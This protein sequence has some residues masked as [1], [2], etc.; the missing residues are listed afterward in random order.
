MLDAA[1]TGFA[2]PVLDGQAAF[3]NLM[4][5]MAR[6]GTVVAFPAAVTPPGSLT[7][8]LA[9][10]ALTLADHETVVWLDPLLAADAAI[11]AWL[12]FHTG[13]RVTADPAEAGF[14][15]LS[16]FAA[17][18]PLGAFAAGD[19]AYPDRSTTLVIAVEALEP[20]GDLALAGPGIDGEQR[21]GV[22][23]W[24]DGLTD[25]LAA[26]RALFPRGVDLVLAAPGAIAA[27]PRTT[28]IK[29]G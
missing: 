8:E 26:N 5:A 12:A 29:E 1:S 3:R 17:L 9:A 14:A 27:L 23:G 13:A 7:A 15:F 2:D 4:D 19:D 16:G 25:A 6:P 24:P 11:G 10:I 18:P 20:V 28:R 22:A 21:L